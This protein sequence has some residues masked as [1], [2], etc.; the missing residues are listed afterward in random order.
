MRQKQVCRV[1]KEKKGE[2]QAAE[3]EGMPGERG[4]GGMDVTGEVTFL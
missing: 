4:D 3:G 1:C 2:G